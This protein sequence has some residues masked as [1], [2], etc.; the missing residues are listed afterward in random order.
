LYE[1]KEETKVVEVLNSYSNVL[2]DF[3]YLLHYAEQAEPFT[4]TIRKRELTF[5]LIVFDLL[6]TLED[7]R[8][9]S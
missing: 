6:S 1:K 9:D 3:Q 4:L 5:F 2:M 8:C 7:V